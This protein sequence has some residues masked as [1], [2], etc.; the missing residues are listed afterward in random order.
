VRERRA[1]DAVGLE[2]A[3]PRPGRHRAGVVEAP[4]R[5]GQPVSLPV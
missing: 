2:A 5:E 1:A 4:A 3:A